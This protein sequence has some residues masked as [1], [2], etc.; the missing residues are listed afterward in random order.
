MKRIIL[1]KKVGCWAN[2]YIDDVFYRAFYDCRK[3]IDNKLEVLNYFRQEGDLK[4]L[5]T[6]KY[7]FIPH[8]DKSFIEILEEEKSIMFKALEF[9]KKD[10]HERL[11]TI[12]INESLNENTKK[13]KVYEKELEIID[14]CIEKLMESNIRSFKR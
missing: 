1:I 3:Y 6:G 4:Q 13:M 14:S 5:D 2:V 12:K 8:R 10:V 7:E 9:Y 11:E